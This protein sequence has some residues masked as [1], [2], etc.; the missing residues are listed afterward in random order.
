VEKEIKVAKDKHNKFLKE[1]GLPPLPTPEQWSNRHLRRTAP[2]GP[3]NALGG[4]DDTK[5]RPDTARK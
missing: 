2:H 5:I 4:Q 3:R 1:L